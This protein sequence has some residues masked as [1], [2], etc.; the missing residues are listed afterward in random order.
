MKRIVTFFI[1]I[2][3]LTVFVFA[4]IDTSNFAFPGVTEDPDGEYIP[5]CSRCERLRL[6]G[7]RKSEYLDVLVMKWDSP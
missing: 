3:L 6:V 7:C 1:C 2:I 5:D 4:N